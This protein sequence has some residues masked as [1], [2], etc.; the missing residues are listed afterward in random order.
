MTYT[1]A[2]LGFL[3]CFLCLACGQ[4]ERERVETQI[5]NVQLF[6]KLQL[7]RDT[8]NA[9]DSLIA[10]L[11]IAY[12]PILTDEIKKEYLKSLSFYLDTASGVNYP[13]QLKD[14]TFRKETEV[15]I[16]SVLFGFVP[17]YKD[18]N[19]DTIIKKD[20]TAAISLGFPE[21]E[22]MTVDT[23]FMDKQTYFLKVKN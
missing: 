8:I 11:S 22:G 13:K 1:Q 3:I 10:T 20:F 4:K 18:W 21:V 19:K 23:T 2:I 14:F 17:N 16:D 12:Q 15:T 5:P 9:G 7:D 6:P